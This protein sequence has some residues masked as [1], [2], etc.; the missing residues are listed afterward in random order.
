MYIVTTQIP[1]TLKDHLNPT[2]RVMGATKVVKQTYE[3]TSSKIYSR[4]IKYEFLL[5]QI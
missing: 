1:K 4:Y 5:K 3:R 2:P